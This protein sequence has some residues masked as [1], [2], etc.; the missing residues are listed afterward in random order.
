VYFDNST[1]RIEVTTAIEQFDHVYDFS[2]HIVYNA[3]SF[4]RVYFEFDYVYSSYFAIEASTGILYTRRTLLPN[5]Y[6]VRV[7][8]EYDVTLLNG[9]VFSDDDYVYITIIAVG[10]D[11]TKH[12]DVLQIYEHYIRM[13]EPGRSKGNLARD[14]PMQWIYSALSK[15]RQLLYQWFY[16][17]NMQQ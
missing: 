13:Q 17:Q 9:T 1:Y 2:K 11:F 15:S 14:L 3:S 5:R 6:T 16:D 12:L 7:E 4:S 10:K 8:I